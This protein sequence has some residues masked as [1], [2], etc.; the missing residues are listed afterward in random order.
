MNYLRL[1]DILDSN[2]ELFSQFDHVYLF[3]SALSGSELSADSDID[4]LL[5]YSKYSDQLVSGCEQISQKLGNETGRVVDLTV[6]GI[7]EERHVGFLDRISPH[8]RKIKL[9]FGRTPGIACRTECFL[10]GFRQ[11]RRRRQRSRLHV[12][13]TAYRTLAGPRLWAPIPHRQDEVP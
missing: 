5:L 12:R 10:R 2:L 8:Y 4:L 9:P 3:G 11:K 1:I 13:H 7:D 6:L